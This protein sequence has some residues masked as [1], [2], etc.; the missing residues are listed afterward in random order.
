MMT[1]RNAYVDLVNCARPRQDVF[2]LALGPGV[3]PASWQAKRRAVAS[4]A[5]T[6]AVPYGRYGGTL[7]LRNA[8]YIMHNVDPVTNWEL[9]LRDTAQL[10]PE[11]VVA[12]VDAA[13]AR[14]RQEADDAA[15]RERG[16]TGTIAAFLRWPANLREAVGSGHP[17]QRTAAGVIG[18]FGQVL[19]GALTTA[20]AT[21]LAA[22]AVAVW[23]LVF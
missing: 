4:A 2:L 20:L 14:A 23:R 8:A 7:T 11:M 17:A 13:I 12:A 5:G 18:I 21:G 22:G 19:V 3:D 1:F 16:F 6:A 9:S 15:Q 10:S